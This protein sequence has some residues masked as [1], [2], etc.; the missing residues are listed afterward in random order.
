M[1][2]T[3]AMF[4]H[5]STA[6]PHT[7]RCFNTH[8]EALQWVIPQWRKYELTYEDGVFSDPDEGEVEVTRDEDG[9][10]R[11]VVHCNGDG[12]VILLLEETD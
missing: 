9:L 2:R 11:A 1:P 10:I 4:K 8:E 12:P 6:D 7:I 5:D 3:I